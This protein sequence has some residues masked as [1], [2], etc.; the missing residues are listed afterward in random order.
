VRK[1]VH[2]Y[3]TKLIPEI[4]VQLLLQIL[5]YYEP[6]KIVFQC[7]KNVQ[8]LFLGF[9]W[10]VYSGQDPK[11]IVE[12]RIREHKYKRIFQSATRLR[13]DYIFIL[14]SVLVSWG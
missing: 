6:I 7:I 12:G 3:R 10:Q 13:L 9:I 4:L 1:N 5:K 2:S 14:L 8:N 11:E